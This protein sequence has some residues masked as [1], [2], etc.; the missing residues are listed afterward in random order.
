[1]SCIFSVTKMSNFMNILFFMG[2]TSIG[3]SVIPG[4]VFAETQ[5]LSTRMSLYEGD[6]GASCADFLGNIAPWERRGGDWRDA[7]GKKFGDQ[8]F[9]VAKPGPQTTVWDVSGMVRGLFSSG[10]QQGGFFLRPVGGSGYVNY[11]SKEA[12]AVTN[13]PMLVLD[14][15]D[16]HRD[17]LK[18]TADT[19]LDCSTFRSLG[20]TETLMVSGAH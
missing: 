14:Y 12:Q 1:M 13:W 15:S 20:Q 4:A 3:F 10:T 7:R 5:D 16:G 18:P 8:P 19:T 17:M 2:L 11:H 6:G 9:A